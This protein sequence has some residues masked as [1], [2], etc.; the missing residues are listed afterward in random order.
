MIAINPVQTPDPDHRLSLLIRMGAH[1]EP[2]RCGIVHPC[3]PG[4]LR[5]AIQS[6][7]QLLITPILIG[8][9]SRILATADESG[10]DISPFEII[11]TP[12]SHASAELAAQIAADASVEALMKGSLHTDEFM[13][14]IV[15]QPK[16][17]TKR[18]ISHIWR[19]E[20]PAYHKPLLI[21]DGAINIAPALMEKMDIVQNA[22]NLAHILGN[23]MPRVA[24]LSA[25]ET[26]N[27]NIASTLDAA[28]LCKM[29]D[30]KQI[31]GGLL[32]GPLAFDNAISLKAAQIKNIESA[33]AGQADILIAPDLESANMLGKQLEYLAGASVSGV[34]LGARIPLALTS[35]ADDA[36]S[37]V[38]SALL[39]KLVAH[40]YRAH[41]P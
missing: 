1:L 15:A 41:K 40:H 16:L 29:A 21:S 13:A 2:I 22:I 6:A 36:D 20:V 5:G 12:H 25:V 11:D 18:R 3:E 10:L 35:R 37:R 34:V 31:T 17:R 7:A 39:A 9:K 32:D 8:P 33:V 30:R 28:A 27:P 23:S 4:A 19:F 14:A 24:I 26:I 38:G